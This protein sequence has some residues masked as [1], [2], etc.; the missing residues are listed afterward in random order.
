[1]FSVM[2][3]M[4]R[5][6]TR[7][8]GIRM[9]LGA[10]RAN[11]ES[12]VLRRG[13]VIAALGTTAGLLGARAVGVLLSGLLFEVTPTDS[14]TFLGVAVAVIVVA[15]LASFFPARAGASVDPVKSLRAD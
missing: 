10:T 6:R 15:A 7:E 3:T 5:R 2:A 8:L 13:L 11:V 1:M 4:V 9:A 12:L 14:L